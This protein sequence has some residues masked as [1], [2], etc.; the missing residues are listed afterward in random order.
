MR[1]ATSSSSI[2]AIMR[3]GPEQRGHASTSIEK[4]RAKSRAQSRRRARSG[5]SGRSGEPDATGIRP[6]LTVLDASLDATAGVLVTIHDGHD[7]S[8]ADDRAAASATLVA[9]KRHARR[10]PPPPLRPTARRPPISSPRRIRRPR[11]RG[12]RAWP[13]VSG[14][15]RPAGQRGRF[16]AL[17]LSFRHRSST[18]VA[19]VPHRDTRSSPCFYYALQPLARPLSI[20]ILSNH[21]NAS[22]ALPPGN[23]RPVPDVSDLAVSHHLL[24]APLVYPIHRA[25]CPDRSS[26][27]RAPSGREDR[28]NTVA[29]RTAGRTLARLRE[30]YPSGYA[31]R[32]R[33]GLRRQ[34]GECGR[35]RARANE[36]EDPKKPHRMHP[37]EHRT[38]RRA[39][40]RRDSRCGGIRLP[41][42]NM[43]RSAPCHS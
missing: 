37:M 30:S 23:E 31:H 24:L 20:V 32:S 43:H 15:D 38:P 27:L 36:C 26:P 19:L 35:G 21:C 16:A 40:S 41:H 9:A 33:I 34:G 6:L 39:R 8:W 25:R 3:M 13:R 18:C 1:C 12:H 14:L 28:I 10:C 29:P 5:S 22:T 2:M 11:D 7:E 42:D 4:V 17:A